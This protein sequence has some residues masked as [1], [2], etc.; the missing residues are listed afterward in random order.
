[1]SFLRAALTAIIALQVFLAPVPASAQLATGSPWQNTKWDF[2]N[3]YQGTTTQQLNP[4]ILMTLD[5]SGSTSR[6]M[7]HPLFPNNWQ[8]ENQPNNPSDSKDYVEVINIGSGTTAPSTCTSTLGKQVLS[9]LSVGFGANYQSTTISTVSAT[10]ITYTIGGNRI[11]V[12]VGSVVYPTN[13]L[14]KPDGTEVTYTDVAAAFPNQVSGGVVANAVAWM[15]C[16]SHIRLR[17]TQYVKG[18]VTT[19]LIRDID[20]PLY[21][22]PIDPT[23]PAPGAGGLTVATAPGPV[24]FDTLTTTTNPALIT[25]ATAHATQSAV[26]IYGGYATTSTIC[27][28]RSRYIEWVFVGKDPATGYYCIPNAIPSSVAGTQSSIDPTSVTYSYHG[29]TGTYSGWSNITSASTTTFG[30]SPATALLPAGTNVCPPKGINIG[31]FTSFDNGL[32]NRS[33]CTA[34]KEALVKTWIAY[35]SKIIFAYRFLDSNTADD[36]L[37][38]GTGSYP[39][40]NWNYVTSAANLSTI[41]AY[42]PNGGTPLVETFLNAYCQM[43]NP[44]AF[45]SQITSL[46]YTDAQ[47]ECQHHFVIVLTDGAPSSIG[48]DNETSCSFP[49][50]T[51][52]ANGCY[53]FSSTDPTPSNEAY[54]GNSAVQKNPNELASSSYFWNP[55]TFAGIAAHGGGDNASTWILN[56]ALSETQSGNLTSLGWVPFWVTKR[57]NAGGTY[58]LIKPQPIQTM[59]VGVSLGVDYQTAGGAAWSTTA[60]GA[61][62]VATAVVPIASDV[63]GSKFRLMTAAMTGN[64]QIETYSVANAVPFYLPTGSTALPAGATYFFDGRD[65]STLVNN[66]NLAF[67]QILEIS[68]GNATSAPV[69]PTV[70]AGL[71]NEVYV[72][73]F[74]PPLNAGP[75]W[76]GDVLMYPIQTGIAGTSLLTSAGTVLTGGVSAATAGWSAANAL[77]NKG[78]INRTIYTR[79]PSASGTAPAPPTALVQVIPGGTGMY[80][81]DPGYGS[82]SGILPGATA[83]AKLQNWQFLVGADVGTGLTPLGTRASTI[84]GDVINSTPTVL[85]YSTLP[86]SLSSGPHANAILSAAWSAHSPTSGTTDKTG[87]FRVVFVGDNSGIFHAF[88]EVS[89]VVQVNG[90]SLTQAVV[91]ELWG[92]VPTELLPNID[93][94]QIT[95]NLHRYAVDGPPTIYLLDLPQSSSQATGNG[96]FQVGATYNPERAMVIFGLGKGGRSYY[97]INIADPGNPSLQWAICPNEEYNASSSSGRL[98]GSSSSTVISNMGLAT[99]QPSIARVSTNEESPAGVLVDAALLGGGYSD[100]NIES[101]LPTTAVASTIASIPAT[102]TLGRSVVAVDVW[103]GKVLRTWNTATGNATAGPVSTA[104]VPLTLTQGTGI[105]SRAYFTDYYG[106]L[107]ALG[108]TTLDTTYNVLRVDTPV[109]DNWNAR[110]VYDQA[111][112]A[113][114]PGNGLVT[115]SPVPFLIPQFPVARTVAPLINPAAVGVAFVTGDRNNPLDSYNY[116]SWTAPTQHRLNVVFDRQDINS[117]I[118]AAGLSNAG[119]G[120]FDTNPIDSTYYL[121]NNL[122]YYANFAPSP[123]ITQN[124]AYIPKG[125]NPPTVLDGNL[126]YS[127]FDP[128]TATCAGG[129]GITTTYQVCNVMSP[130]INT[131]FAS[132]ATAVAGCQSGAVLS[133]TGVA[134]NISAQSI[135]LAVQ[136]GLTSGSG[137]TNN[138][139]SPQNLTLQ[140]LNV[141]TLDKFPKVRIW[142][143]VH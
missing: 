33:R 114:S 1:M 59:T 64:P 26:A 36:S 68:E 110:Q 131:S 56:P 41:A 100:N 130:V 11:T 19:P 27:S 38:D 125:I 14:I 108:G 105:T 31:W 98:L 135:L 85:Q 35:Q 143:V 42:A 16:A 75:L 140:N 25:T 93:Q 3:L 79:L 73:S 58:T 116:T 90:I 6:L 122:G 17:M 46:G 62:T 39:N 84:M 5:Q 123:G 44:N 51:S 81:G 132:T 63:G 83:A 57:T 71:G 121:K 67:S 119:A 94:L 29:A 61:P 109:I 32:P 13:C 97:A 95:T 52:S 8:D 20:F 77:V 99:T 101:A 69:F 103:S 43:D 129:T 102:T 72:A 47:L 106:S 54:A 70:G 66:L 45:Q 60:N 78:W 21:W 34:I 50:N 10:G 55:S 40:G 76:T 74:T 49:Y 12:T 104:V 86:P 133:W 96:I 137:N 89:Y 65:P 138:P 30:N 139:A 141:S 22:K 23:C 111:V 115:T 107:W 113:G 48:A 80:T 112:T 134:S 53:S 91:D 24:S 2:L 7:F 127:V 118:S 128:Q 28:V 136:A 142:R 88:G 37:T 92:F 82:I 9:G 87:G 120:G 4:E 18:G 117:L 124:V 126:F 15:M